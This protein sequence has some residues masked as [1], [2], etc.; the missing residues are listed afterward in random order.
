MINLTFEVIS[1]KKLS[2]MI[3]LVLMLSGCNTAVQPSASPSAKPTPSTTPSPSPIIT[4]S[5][6]PT[7]AAQTMNI[8]VFY[9]K[10]KQNE[11]YLVREVHKVPKT[12]GVANA[13]LKELISGTVSNQGAYRV[14]PA[15]TKVLG[16]KIENG[17]AT[18]DFSK[19]VLKANVGSAAEA[20]GI[21]SIVNTLTEFPTIQKVQFTVEGS[22]ESAKSW[23]G[24]VG[25]YKQPFIR[26]LSYV[27]EPAIWVN[28]P[29][30][31]QKIS[32][33]FT[34]RGNAR[35]FEATV[36]YRLKDSA[37]NILAQGSTMASAGAPGRG[38]FSK[39]ITFA[40]KSATSGQLEVF[41]ESMK[42][43]SD[44]NKVIIPVSW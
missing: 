9:L 30:A 19:D 6:S 24:H 18:V 27:F 41:E 20:R 3:A 14:L 40:P 31:G 10:E 22:S 29:E 33:S 8:A 38:D 4:P 26:D 37:G 1:I 34:F 5:S 39:T 15:N 28:S 17:I 16:I 7:G 35:V 36:S 2:I 25:L 23:W 21:E 12:E 13:A 43:G 11:L 44:M 42:D 32:S